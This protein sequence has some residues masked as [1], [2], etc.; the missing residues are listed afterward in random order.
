M[1]RRPAARVHLPQRLRTGLDEETDGRVGSAVGA[2]RVERRRAVNALLGKRGGVRVNKGPDYFGAG[3]GAA[4]DVEHRPAPAKLGLG[5]GGTLV[6]DLE[7]EWHFVLRGVVLEGFL[8]LV[9]IHGCRDYV[10]G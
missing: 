2:C 6:E 7:D 3:G 9:G 4:G 10:E 8:Q 5:R 1:Q